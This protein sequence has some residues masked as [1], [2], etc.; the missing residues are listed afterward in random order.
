MNFLHKILLV[1]VMADGVANVVLNL[2]KD[3][4]VLSLLASQVRMTIYYIKMWVTALAK[5]MFNLY[6]QKNYYEKHFVY[7]T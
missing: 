4:I 5:Y 7:A 3:V 2:L 6:N 1:A